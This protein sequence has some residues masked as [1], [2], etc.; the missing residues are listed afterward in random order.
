MKASM[1]IFL[2][3]CIPFGITPNTITATRLV[4]GVM[5]I[6]FYLQGS[7]WA[8]LIVFSIASV[9]DYL[10]G[11]VARARGLASAWGKRFDE[12]TDKLLILGF[13]AVIIYHL[14]LQDMSPSSFWLA[15]MAGI[16]VV[17]EMFMSFARPR[18]WVRFSGVLKSAKSKT[19]AQMLA[20]GFLII[21]DI[22]PFY[23]SMGYVLLTLAAVLGMY[24]MYFYLTTSDQ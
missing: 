15:Q 2:L 12:L 9:T 1:D 4:M 5:A 18:G 10:D 22:H 6:N 20:V 24:S 17:R 11:L 21:A 13:L 3:R 16:V 19:A 14:V 7:L 23:Y 8:A